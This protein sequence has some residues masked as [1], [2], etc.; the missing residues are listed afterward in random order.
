MPFEIITDTS[1]GLT[2]KYATK[3]NVK[4]VSFKYYFGEEEFDTYQ[5]GN[6]DEWIRTFYERLRKKES[7]NT[8]L[9]NA[10]TFITAFTD[11]LNKGKD[12]IYLAFSSALSATYEQALGVVKKLKPLYPD[13]KMYVFDTKSAAQGQALNVDFA[14]RQ[15]D[16][17]DSL[18]QIYQWQVDNTLK[19]CHW[20][21]VDDLFFLKR[22]GRISGATAVAGTVLGIKP[23]MHVNNDGKLIKVDTARGR[24]A[25]LD[26]LVKKF[27]ETAIN[28]E[29]HRVF[30]GHGDCPEDL[31]YV[32]KQLKEKFGVK[33]F[34]T[35]FVNPVIGVHSGP[36]TMTL[37]FYGTG[38]G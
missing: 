16:R 30:M 37:F 12:F 26:Y 11:I 36:G 28:P 4:I 14:V 17:G 32:Q 3:N 15:R 38:R 27:G 34:E 1:A 6:N 31:K 18:E 9:I 8:A 29:N 20:F 5:P 13:R 23:I 25:S 19:I 35:G 21:T 7:A 10:D 2:Y 22:G 24:R 33:E